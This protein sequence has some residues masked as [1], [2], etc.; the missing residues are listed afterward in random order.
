M[1][2]DNCICK[3]ENTFLTKWIQFQI[4]FRNEV[5]TVGLTAVFKFILQ[6]M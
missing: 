1:K 6:Y 5:V 3:W 2:K 4:F